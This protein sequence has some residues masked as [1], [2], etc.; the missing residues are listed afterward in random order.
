MVIGVLEIAGGVLL[1]VP[2]ATSYAAALLAVILVAA[3]VTLALHQQPMSPPL[4]WLVAM[5]FLGLARRRRA[6]RPGIRALPVT[7]NQV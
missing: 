7:A 4:V 5:I 6:W 1:L 3:A 2:K